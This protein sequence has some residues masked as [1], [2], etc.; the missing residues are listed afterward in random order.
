MSAGR[1]F[2]GKGAG[3]A[4]LIGTS[5]FIVPICPASPRSR[6]TSRHCGRRSP[7]PTGACCIRTTAGQKAFNGAQAV[8]T[9]AGHYGSPVRAGTADAGTNS[10]EACR[11]VAESNP[12]GADTDAGKIT[13]GTVRCMVAT[14]NQVAKTTFE[15]VDSTDASSN[16][17]AD[18]PTFE[19]SVT[20]WAAP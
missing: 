1:W 19:L 8:I 20:V 5:R 14:R 10:G 2:P 15:K 11:A 4:V 13:P 6:P 17:R 9:V 7:T 18:N 3:R 12:L 16:A